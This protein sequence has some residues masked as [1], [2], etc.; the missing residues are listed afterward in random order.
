[1]IVH[2]HRFLTY[3]SLD[4]DLGCG[5]WNFYIGLPLMEKILIFFKLY[6]SPVHNPLKRSIYSRNEYNKT[7]SPKYGQKESRVRSQ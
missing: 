2:C 1:M 4:R 3:M 5:V 7:M 6:N